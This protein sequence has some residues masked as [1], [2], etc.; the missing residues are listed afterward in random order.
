MVAKAAYLMVAAT[1]R[2]D[3]ASTTVP[4]QGGLGASPSGLPEAV[5]D[6][7]H[8]HNANEEPEC[9]QLTTRFVY[10]LARGAPSRG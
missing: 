7:R 6:G 8:D 1:I 10:S 9:G 4:R 3:F 2:P 5:A